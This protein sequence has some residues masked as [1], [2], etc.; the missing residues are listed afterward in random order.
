M[1]ARTNYVKS[2]LGSSAK[3][4]L[5]KLFLYSL[6]LVANAYLENHLDQ[7][8]SPDQISSFETFQDP[9]QSCI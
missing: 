7:E 1:Y 3:G 5:L 8:S 2:V 6:R 4:F 9:W